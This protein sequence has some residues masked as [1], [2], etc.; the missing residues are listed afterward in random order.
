MSK[1]KTMIRKDIEL[2]DELIKNGFAKNSDVKI[3]IGKYIIDYPEFD[4]GIISYVNVPGC[5]T[6]YID[7]IRIIKGK[8]EYLL[9]RVDN[10][11]LYNSKN[12]KDKRV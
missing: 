12:E 8:L 10:P 6:N 11:E 2:C 1:F 9:G 7:N 3:L 4:K 5:D